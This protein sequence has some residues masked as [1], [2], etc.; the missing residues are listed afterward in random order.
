MSTMSAVL[1]VLLYTF[2]IVLLIV[3][4]ILGIK[5][6]YLIE[7]AD[8]VLTRMEDRMNSF[9]GVFTAF[10]RIN[11]TIVKLT[12]GFTFSVIDKIS[13]IFRKNKRKEDDYE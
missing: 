6:I 12:D 7:K 13:K 2:G 11:N 5:L 8:R 4:I 3:L 1:S 9:N 10:D